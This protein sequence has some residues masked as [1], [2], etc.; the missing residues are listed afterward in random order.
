MEDAYVVERIF[1]SDEDGTDSYAII[2]IENRKARTVCIGI[3]SEQEA[4]K[5]VN[6]LLWYETFTSGS[7]YIPDSSPSFHKQKKKTTRPKKKP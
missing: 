2:K 6:S 1:A 7:I 4:N 5:I 3:S